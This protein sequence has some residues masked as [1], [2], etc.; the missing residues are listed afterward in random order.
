[1]TLRPEQDAFGRALLDQLDGRSAWEIIERDDGHID[2]S[3]HAS[4]YFDEL[5]GSDLDAAHHAR[6]RVLDV[7]CGAGRFALHLQA[8]GHDVVAIDHSP[9]AI[10]VC[11]RRGVR[12]ARVLPVARI[13]RAIGPFD[14]ILLMGN[15]LGLLGN[16]TRA[17]GLLR[18]FHRITAESGS[19]VAESLDP[20][21]TR[22]PLHIAYHEANRA[23][24]RMGGQIRMRVRYRCWRTPWFDYL[25]VSVAE[26]D[27]LL[28]GT[29]WHRARTVQ[30]GGPGWITVL[31]KT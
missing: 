21:H 30:T 11:R 22:D 4:A 14:T 17:H 12:D 2:V 28:E 27:E 16:R 31:E 25:F 6:G 7:G 24:G 5:E 9:G 26:M 23:R 13:G 10:E 8:R 18:R 19:I 3:S 15:N 20:Y 1:M 29:G